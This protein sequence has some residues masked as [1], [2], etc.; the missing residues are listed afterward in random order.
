MWKWGTQSALSS[1][2]GG[3]VERSV[4]GDKR[5]LSQHD[6]CLPAH[7]PLDDLQTG[8]SLGSPWSSEPRAPTQAQGCVGTRPESH[9]HPPSP[10]P[11]YSESLVGQGLTLGMLPHDFGW[12][13]AIHRAVEHTSFA[14]DA[15]LVVGLHHEPRGHCRKREG[16]RNPSPQSLIGLLGLQAPASQCQARLDCSKPELPRALAGCWLGAGSSELQF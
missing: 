6:S 11:G 4:C 16:G 10:L 13:V 15:V 9:Q 2:A 1:R 14:I 3:E 7:R 12:G 8:C 5:T